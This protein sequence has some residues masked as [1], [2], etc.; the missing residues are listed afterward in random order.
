MNSIILRRVAVAALIAFAP[1]AFA[2]V[3]DD[4]QV[5]VNQGQ[6]AEALKLLDTQLSKNPQDAEARA[7]S[8]ACAAQDALAAAIGRRDKA[9]AAAEALLAEAER[10]V[11]AA[12]ANV[13]AVSGVERA[14]ALLGV[15]RTALRKARTIADS[16]TG[17]DGA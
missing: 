5:L 6:L 2:S 9:V 1:C 16:A 13:V 4:A 11:A 8:A 15:N 17:G 14:S 7:V 3:A 10:A 12:Q